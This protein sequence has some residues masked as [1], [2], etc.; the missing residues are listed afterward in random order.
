[1]SALVIITIVGFSVGFRPHS[2]LGLILGFAVLLGFTLATSFMFGL[3]GL[4]ASSS[5]AVNAATFP[6]IFP[7]TFASS[8]FVPTSTMPS[9]LR[10]FAN[11][12]PV[13]IVIDAVR[14]LTLGNVTVAQRHQ[15]FA[16]QSTTALVVQ[17][18][19]WTVAI[20]LVF[21]S[22][23]VRRYNSTIS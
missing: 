8:A 17:S 12:Q 19:I 16:G 21:G 18:L 7:L 11:H 4:Y 15:L 20:G 14:D 3:V 22:L 6:V 10:A 2:A 9:W 5:Q 23:A 13:T 1:M